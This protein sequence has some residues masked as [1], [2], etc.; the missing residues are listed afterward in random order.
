MIIPEC[1][2]V[3]FKFRISKY[4]QTPRKMKGVYQTLLAIS[5]IDGEKI[6]ELR[7]RHFQNCKLLIHR[8]LAA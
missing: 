1:V 2:V 3:N 6:R 4:F 5:W 7:K 8:D